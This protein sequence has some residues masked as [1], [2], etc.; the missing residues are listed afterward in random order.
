MRR[1]PSFFTV[2][3]AYLSVYPFLITVLAFTGLAFVLVRAYGPEIKGLVSDRPPVRIRQLQPLPTNEV[4][5]EV[6][7]TVTNLPDGFASIPIK[8]VS[9]PTRSTAGSLSSVANSEGSQESSISVPLDENPASGSTSNSEIMSDVPLGGYEPQEATRPPVAV[10]S[11]PTPT[12]SPTIDLV[13]DFPTAT[14]ARHRGATATP[15]PAGFLEGLVDNLRQAIDN[16]GN[17]APAGDRVASLPTFTPT[18]TGTSTPTATAIPTETLTPTPL[19]DTPTPTITP[20]FTDTPSPTPTPLPTNTPVPPPVLRPTATSLPTATPEPE[21]DF[22]LNEFY[23]SPTTNSFIVVYVAIVD[24]NDIPI[25]DMKIVGTRLDHNLTYE[26]PLSTW[27]YEGYNAPG[28]VR[29]SGNVKFEP[30][31][32]IEST[33]WV[34]YLADANGNRLSADIPFHTDAN[35]KQWYFVKFRRRY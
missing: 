35:D 18:P 14:P 3:L 11:L 27:H 28:E 13:F 20:A 5:A 29:K 25:G 7:S 17:G 6:A 10:A 4:E 15:E 26:S 31:G 23:N 8:K 12:P 1:P 30:P 22:L 21:Y 9:Q 24:A 16:S 32:G 19:P 2:L 33:K 34:I